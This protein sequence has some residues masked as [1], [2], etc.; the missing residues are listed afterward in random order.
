MEER[1]YIVHNTFR[2]SREVRREDSVHFL[3]ES[4]VFMYVGSNIFAKVQVDTCIANDKPI[5]T[6]RRHPAASL[7]IS[8]GR[9]LV[10]GTVLAA[11]KQ[12]CGSLVL[13]A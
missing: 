1:D 2:P 10:E 4:I 13:L 11:R 5:L 7:V 8:L 9:G 3:E 6:A 12:I